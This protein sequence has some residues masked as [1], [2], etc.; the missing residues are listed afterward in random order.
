MVWRRPQHTTGDGAAW[1]IKGQDGAAG[2]H[3][4]GDVV[5]LPG[6]ASA[7]TATCV[8]TH[9][10][11]CSNIVGGQAACDAESACAYDSGNTVCTAADAAVCTA[12]AANGAAACAGAGACTYH[13]GDGAIKLADADGN[14]VVTV[15]DNLVTIQQPV[16]IQLSASDINAGH[17]GIQSNGDIT[18]SGDVHAS[19]AN[20]E[21]LVASVSISTPSIISPTDSITMGDDDT[22]T[23]GRPVHTSGDGQDFIIAG[24]DGAPGGNGGDL[25]LQAGSHDG[26]TSHGQV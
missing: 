7:G 9:A 14:A 11:Y 13:S 16:S 20:V 6:R 23:L 12:E 25:V 22:F 15:R 21:T 17:A 2:G 8:A 5:L 4:G 1:S 26:G 24:Q 18:T 3:S 10:V 19:G